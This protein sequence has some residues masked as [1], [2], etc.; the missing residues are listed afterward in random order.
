VRAMYAAALKDFPAT[1]VRPRTV[2]TP[3]AP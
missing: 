2:T 1:G 3:L